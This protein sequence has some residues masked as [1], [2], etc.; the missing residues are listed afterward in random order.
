[1]TRFFT[2]KKTSGITTYAHKP[3]WEQ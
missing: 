1:M 3:S 2:G